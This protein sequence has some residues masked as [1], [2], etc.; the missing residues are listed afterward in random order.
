MKTVTR[1]NIVGYIRTNKQARVAQL[2]R[3]FGISGVAIHK[4]LKK[5][6]DDGVLA[7]VGSAPQVFYV[8]AKKTRKPVS[9]N[10]NSAARKLI[11][12]HYLYISPQGELKYG[13]NGLARWAENTGQGKNVASLAQ[14]YVRTWQEYHKY[15]NRHGWVEATGKL[16]K[17]FENSYMDK[18]FYADFYSL[19][20]FGK[21]KLGALVLYAKQSQSRQLA[22]EI[23][24]QIKQLVAD[25][26]K[27]YKIEAI[28]FIPPSIPRQ[29]QLMKEMEVC[30]QFGLPRVSLIKTRTG[31]VIVAQK[32]LEKL[33]ERIANARDTIFVKE[34]N[35]TYRRILLIDDAVGS[36]A[37]MNET[38]KK[39]KQLLPKNGQVIGFA[40]VGSMKDFEVLRE[41]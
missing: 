32:T 8:L 40:P 23:C 11:D 2:I 24:E 35:L 22:V 34:A 20:Q 21:T 9:V 29:V 4:Q 3:V 36:G 19:S 10:I 5:L 1:E 37:S 17:T 13:S 26:I 39:I 16:T 41:V 7:K 33:P 31:Q 12:R 14:A 6:V 15:R 27:T 30:L 38:A 25:I 18:L 28:G